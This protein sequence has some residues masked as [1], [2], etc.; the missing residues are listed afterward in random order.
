MCLCDVRILRVCV[1]GAAREGGR[2]SVRAPRRRRGAVC[3]LIS[4]LSGPSCTSLKG[5][6]LAGL[7][8]K[9]GH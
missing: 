8:T 7:E 2:A 5:V 4:Y 3:L 1:C 9:V 6:T